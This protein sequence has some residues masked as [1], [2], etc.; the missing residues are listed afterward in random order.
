[1]FLEKYKIKSEEA[2]YGSPLKKKQYHRAPPHTQHVQL[3]SCWSLN[4]NLFNCY[5]K[6]KK[7][8]HQIGAGYDPLESRIKIIDFWLLLSFKIQ[9]SRGPR[10][11]THAGSKPAKLFSHRLAILVE[12]SRHLIHKVYPWL[13]QIVLSPFC[14]QMCCDEKNFI[15]SNFCDC[16]LV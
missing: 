14:V 3:K 11:I 15:D 9:I 2:R 7:K 1:M 5:L 4:T 6:S 16:I 10:V 12:D 8:V 13:I